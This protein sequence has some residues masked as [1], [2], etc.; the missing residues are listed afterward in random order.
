MSKEW[1]PNWQARLRKLENTTR[2]ERPVFKAL[3]SFY[4][5]SYSRPMV[6]HSLGQAEK[7]GD[8]ELISR[9]RKKRDGLVY[10]LDNLRIWLASAGFA[11][12]A[13]AIV[14]GI[15]D[16]DRKFLSRL[17]EGLVLGEVYSFSTQCARFLCE[18]FLEAKTPMGTNYVKV[19]GFA[20]D[21]DKELKD[22]YL[23]C[24]IQAK[25]KDEAREF[26][27]GIYNGHSQFFNALGAL[28]ETS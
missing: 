17:P 20:L 24:L 12:Q 21:S 3:A 25:E 11:E 15:E 2:L 8:P 23:S 16:F 14:H 27:R 6:E 7:I 22:D 9:V 10:D 5:L 28:G 4:L 13:V 26:L 1:E 18:D 19:L